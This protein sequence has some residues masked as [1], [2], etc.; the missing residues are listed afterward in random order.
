MNMK[1]AELGNTGIKVSRICVG[2]MSFGEPSEDFHRWTLSR[3][4]TKEVIG[5]C[6]EN[7]IN[8]IDTANTYSH[9]TSEEFIGHALRSWRYPART[10]SWHPRCTSTR[11]IS[12]W[13]PYSGRST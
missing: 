1:Y 7:G 9:G 13:R 4:E 12:A 6:F 11:D 3:E 5:F 8:F 10:S 2:G